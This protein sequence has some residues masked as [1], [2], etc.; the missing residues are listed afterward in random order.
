VFG[1]VAV[2]LAVCVVLQPWERNGAP[3]TAAAQLFAERAQN[4]AT[5]NGIARPPATSGGIQRGTA[6]TPD[7]ASTGT[8]LSGAQAKQPHSN[9]HPA[10]SSGM[11]SLSTF[12]DVLSSAKSS[13]SPARSPAIATVVG[14]LPPFSGFG[15][16]VVTPQ[17]ARASV[18]GSGGS[19]VV[20]EVEDE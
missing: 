3:A 8:P 1:C 5:S 9:G 14:A 20:E 11:A 2:W 16:G 4:A 18:D 12:Q 17:T 10:R 6:S 15:A 7:V 13:G 19:V